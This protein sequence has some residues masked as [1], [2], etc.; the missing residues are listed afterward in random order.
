MVNTKINIML[1]FLILN[2]VLSLVIGIPYFGGISSNFQEL[3]FVFTAYISNTFMLYA[4]MALLIFPFFLFKGG[5]YLYM[6]ICVLF[7]MTLI[8]DVAI[9][10]IF[11]FHINPMVMNILTSKAGFATLEQ[12]LGMQLFAVF[13]LLVIVGFEIW[14]IRL[15][16]KENKF[17]NKKR[18]VIA[19]AALFLFVLA[20]K[21][22]YAYGDLKDNVFITR[23]HKVFPLYQPL[24][25]KHFAIKYLGVKVDKKVKVKLSKKNSRLDYP[26]NKITFNGKL[27]KKPNIIFLVGEAVRYDM[28]TAEIMPNTYD[29]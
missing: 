12:G 28:M 20:D 21:G 23:N 24:T 25:I 19:V 5:R 17:I 26:K 14:F 4:V 15:A 2:F 22:M 7:Q 8:V 9:Y 10:K 18:K 13:L 27:N 6:P 11:K 3:I 16:S 1:S 29:L